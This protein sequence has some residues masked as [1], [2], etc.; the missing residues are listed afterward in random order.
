MEVL[1]GESG[2]HGQVAAK[3]LEIIEAEFHQSMEISPLPKY[4]QKM[5]QKIGNI[6]GDKQSDLTGHGL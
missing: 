1:V 3:E 6:R 4:R 5:R 2:P